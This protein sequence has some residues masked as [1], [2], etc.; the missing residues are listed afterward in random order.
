MKER[1]KALLGFSKWTFGRKLAVGVVALVVLFVVMGTIRDATAPEPEFLFTL[2]QPFWVLALVAFTVGGLSFLSPCTLPILPAYFA[3]AF[4]SGRR[5]IATNTL[6]FMLGVATMFSLFG[7]GASALGAVLR[8]DQDLILLLGGALVVV[9]GMMSLLGRGF[10]GIQKEEEQVQPRTLGGSFLFGVTF[11]VGWSTCIGPILGA[12]MTMAATTGSVVRGMMLL[13]IYALGLGLPLMV[14]S[15]FLGRT[16]RKSLVWRLMR[17]KGWFVKVPEVV[18]V[19]LW[20]LVVGFLL[21]AV[22]RY[23]FEHWA[24][25]GGQTFTAGHTAVLFVIAILGGLLWLYTG[26]GLGNKTE[27][28]LHTTQ[29]VSGVLFLTLGVL[30]LN[31]EMARITAM[32]SGG[33]TWLIEV[34]EALYRL[35]Q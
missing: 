25:F 4:Q 29:L 33:E 15:T 26:Q 12:V 11:A 17:G 31:G 21:T 35:L 10:S 20:S 7:A 3:F 9:F 8:R 16:S 23:G 1:E 30:M 24:V 19:L 5:Q 28:H 6:A 34:E 27:L 2:Q 18:P 32:L 22:V 13:F 14:V